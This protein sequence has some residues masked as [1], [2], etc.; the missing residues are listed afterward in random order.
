MNEK[1]VYSF[2]GGE[3]DGGT[4][5][6]DLLGGKGSNLHEMT[7]LGINVP[8]GF[9]ITTNVCTY[10]VNNNDYP[11]G[12][13]E[14]VDEALSNIED[15]MGKEFGSTENPLLLSVR[16]GARVSMPGMMDTV[17]NIGLNDETVKGL[18][19]QTN[20]ER[21]AYDSYRRFVQMYG[22]V[23][24]GL[25]NADFEDLIDQKKEEVGA[26]V[27]TDLDVQALKELVVEFKELVETKA[28]IDF[29]E[30]PEDQ[31]WGAITAVFGSWD[32]QRAISY[33]EINDIPHHWG[34]AVNVQTMVYGNMG[35]DCG[36]GVAF[37]RDPSTGE[38]KY[39]GEYLH[40]AQGEDVVAGIRTPKDIQ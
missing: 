15:L 14:E 5:M 32:N 6:G 38:K 3:A 7:K 29:P 30:K 11:D 20:D 26:E 16:S 36:T 33:R 28:D 18:A 27:D 2:G 19:K 23:V 25:D 24:V 10:Y 8:P 1:M 12:L 9:T 4:E 37:T 34:T 13:E 22:G 31:L 17:L 21:F 39:W 40:N 35:E